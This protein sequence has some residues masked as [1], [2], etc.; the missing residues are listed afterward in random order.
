LPI[1]VSAHNF[2]LIHRLRRA[3]TRKTAFSKICA[4]VVGQA[5]PYCP[6]NAER[7]PR[8]PSV[9]AN[10][11]FIP[12]GHDNTFARNRTAPGASLARAEDP[13][14]CRRAESTLAISI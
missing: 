7:F 14:A 1:P 11:F 10:E 9:C 2:F 13:A 3:A 8:P 6:K 4:Q 5:F 12:F